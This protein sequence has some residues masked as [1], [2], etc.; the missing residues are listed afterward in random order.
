M[1][2]LGLYMVGAAHEGAGWGISHYSCGCALESEMGMEREGRILK[3]RLKTWWHFLLT[4]E[5]SALLFLFFSDFVVRVL[6]YL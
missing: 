5:Y 4:I 6:S 1:A 3:I 2:D